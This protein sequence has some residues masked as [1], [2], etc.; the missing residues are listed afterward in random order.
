MEIGLNSKDGVNND[1]GINVPLSGVK[2]FIIIK[3]RQNCGNYGHHF[4]GSCHVIAITM[5]YLYIIK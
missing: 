2:T 1:H 5:S 4:S 3:R